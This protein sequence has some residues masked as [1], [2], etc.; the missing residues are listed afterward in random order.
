[1]ELPYRLMQL[2]TYGGEV[3]LDP[4]MGSGQTAIAALKGGR[5]FVGYEIEEN[6]LRLAERRVRGFTAENGQQFL[7]SGTN[8]VMEG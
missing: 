1:V 4:F 6:Y 3:V 7:F 5:R 2:Y 8:L